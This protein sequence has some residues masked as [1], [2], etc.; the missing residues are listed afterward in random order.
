[1]KYYYIK[2]DRQYYNIFGTSKVA[3][4]AQQFDGKFERNKFWDIPEPLLLTVYAED[5]DENLKFPFYEKP[6]MG[7]IYIMIP[8]IKDILSNFSLPN[9][10]W[11][12][13][14]AIYNQ[15]FIQEMK[16]YFNIEYD[17]NISEEKD[18]SVLQLLDTKLEEL[19]FNRMEWFIEGRQDIVRKVEKEIL[20]YNEY[21]EISKGVYFESKTHID[22]PIYKYK[23]NYDIL[24][25]GIH[26]VFNE[27]V[28]AA[29]EQTNIISPKNGL[30]FAEFTDYEIE[31]LGEEN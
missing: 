6:G 28:K 7:Y 15:E 16:T 8:E 22:S 18:Y 11:Y 24:W 27:K 3:L 19:A 9:H 20:S 30:E 10:K 26:I 23:K 13:A 31:M 1:M 4:D 21:I 14:K 17:I 5:G 29:L 12:S 2:Q 25:G